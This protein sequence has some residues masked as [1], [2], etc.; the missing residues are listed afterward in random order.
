[1]E[2]IRNSW[3]VT[4]FADDLRNEVGGKYSLIGIYTIDLILSGV[5]FPVTLPKFCVLIRYQEV[6]GA[7]TD[8]VTISVF[9]PGDKDEATVS[10]V[11][12]KEQRE[13]AKSPYIIE[14]E[15]EHIFDVTIPVMLSP[16][17]IKEEG[18]IM[19]RAKC[20]TTSQ[21]LDDW[22]CGKAI[23]F[24]LEL[25]VSVQSFLCRS[26]CNLRPPLRRHLS[27]SRRTALLAESLRPT[28]RTSW[29][30]SREPSTRQGLASSR[31]SDASS[32]SSASRSDAK[33]QPGTSDL[34]SASP[35]ASASQTKR[36]RR[37]GGN[38]RD[39]PQP[40][41]APLKTLA[42]ESYRDV[43]LALAATGLNAWLVH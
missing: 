27:R 22:L 21:N 39:L 12:T 3:G 33:R 2:N 4:T 6:K 30:S 1:M 37:D 29:P 7:I 34:S 42:G 5:E 32:G 23:P 11:I 17:T 28:K 8:D 24:P 14:G 19:V 35:P 10:T 20:G 41:R 40:R 15:Q 26:F 36:G 43:I 25:L 38:F 9:L 16:L 31:A 18:S 13:S